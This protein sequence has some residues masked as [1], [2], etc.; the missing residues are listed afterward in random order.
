MQEFRSPDTIL[1]R[2]GTHLV[3]TKD[4][5]LSDLERWRHRCA[6]SSQVFLTAAQ[7]CRNRDPGNDTVDDL[8]V[9]TILQEIALQ[10]YQRTV[11]ALS[12]RL[13]LDTASGG[14]VQR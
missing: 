4:Q 9:A 14:I 7:R 1:S 11:D 8:K 3:E 10:K 6:E 5:L 13:K 2:M 12:E